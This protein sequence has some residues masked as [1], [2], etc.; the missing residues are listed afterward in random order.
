MPPNTKAASVARADGWWFV[1]M[2]GGPDQ[3]KFT[4]I[5]LISLMI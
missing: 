2:G 4:L 1:P 5:S 3:P